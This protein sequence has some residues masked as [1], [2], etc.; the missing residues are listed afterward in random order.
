MALLQYQ[1]LDVPLPFNCFSFSTFFYV[2]KQVKF[3]REG[4][5]VVCFYGGQAPMLTLAL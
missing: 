5:S 1:G 4:V 2:L 3:R